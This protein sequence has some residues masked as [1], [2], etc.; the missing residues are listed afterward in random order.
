MQKRLPGIISLLLCG[1]LIYNSL[2]YFFMLSAMKYSVRQQ[3][4]EQ[5][6]CIPEAQLVKFV[7]PLY[8]AENKY[9]ILNSREIEVDNKLYDVV[10]KIVNDSYITYLC[11][12]DKQ[13]QDLI[14]KIRIYNDKA[15][16]SPSKGTVLL[17]N[18]KILKTALLYLSDKIFSETTSV[19]YSS[20]VNS[21]YK[22]PLLKADFQPP[23]S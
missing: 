3:K 2:G 18:E 8:S 13:E 12:H 17:I 6:N 21:I 10:K 7:F 4:W 15:H 5:L 9:K 19:S 23:K 1:L 22:N 11:V 16:Q 14:A 20:F